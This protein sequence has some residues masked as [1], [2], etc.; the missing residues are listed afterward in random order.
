MAN[1]GGLSIPRTEDAI[2][3][4]T[5]DALR[6]ADHGTLFR[7]EDLDDLAGGN[8][9]NGR[10]WVVLR[11]Q[12]ELERRDK[13]TLV[14]VRGVGYRIGHPEEHLTSG[15]KRRLRA[16]H[17]AAGSVRVLDAADLE[18]IADPSARRAIQNM[19]THMRAM[20]SRLAYN[21]QRADAHERRIAST[22]SEQKV[23]S[24]RIEHLESTVRDLVDKMATPSAD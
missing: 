15:N 17:A 5:Y 22:A 21:E 4:A 10:R 18:Q 11:A 19:S 8:T 20:E 9:R 23:A 6:A 7:Y 14:N 16:K 24:D 12:K 13:R 1:P 2:W 3:R